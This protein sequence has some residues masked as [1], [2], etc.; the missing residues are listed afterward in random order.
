MSDIAEQLGVSSRTVHRYLASVYTES[1]PS[2]TPGDVVVLMDATY[3]GRNFGVVIMKD[4][5]S[6]RVLWYKFINKKETLADYREGIDSLL[7]KGC[8]IQAIVSDGLKGLREQFP[9]HLFQLCQF[10]QQK[11]VITRLT[12]HPKLPASQELLGIAR[13][14]CHTDKESFVAALDHWC[15]KWKGFINERAKGSD[16]KT[17]YIHKNTR[18]AYLSLRRNM[19]WL[20]TWYDHPEIDIPNTNN[21][22]EALNSVLK[23]KLNVHKG[24][25]VERRK[26]LIQGLINAHATNK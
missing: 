13:L 18:S 14:L 11:T 21:E 26:A 10:H 17:H 19:K 8:R 9:R 22:L 25:T 6:G 23:A 3:W 15:D 20:W 1:L 16:G 4:H 24:L 12:L 2:L 5:L 7:A